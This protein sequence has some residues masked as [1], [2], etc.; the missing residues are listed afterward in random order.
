MLLWKFGK[1]LLI[2][3]PVIFVGWKVVPRVLDG[4]ERTCHDELSLLLALTICLVTAAVTEAAGL[5]L[6]LGAFVGGMLLGSSDYVHKLAAQTMPIRDAFVA[7]FFVTVG[8]LIDPSTWLSNWRLLA[9]MVGLVIVG[10]FAI[11]FG[12]V[13]LFGYPAKTAMRVGIGLTQ[14]GEFSFVLAEVAQHAGLIGADVFNATL[15]ASL[16][17]ILV[18]AAMFKAIKQEAAVAGAIA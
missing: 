16:V 1:A 8:M 3:V 12:I 11:W 2:L 15:E 6:A 14:I 10:K 7:L 13:K 17:T 4:V 18:N 9:V 5:S